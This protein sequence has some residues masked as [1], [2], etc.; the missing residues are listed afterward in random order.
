MLFKISKFALIAVL[1]VIAVVQ[2]ITYFLPD[3]V[4]R[5][6]ALDVALPENLSGWK[7]EVIPLAQTEELQNQTQEILRFDEVLSYRYTRGNDYITVYIAY[8]EPGKVPIRKVGV[9]TPDTCWVLNGWKREDRKYS[10]AKDVNGIAL[11]PCEYGLFSI[12]DHFE[13]VVFWHLVGG[14]VHSYE[15]HGLHDLF[16][17]IRD[18]FTKGLNQK[19]DQ[20]FI[21]ISSN[22]DLNE[23][24]Y[25]NGVQELIFAVGKLGAFAPEIDGNQSA[26]AATD[27]ISQ[28]TR[29]VSEVSVASR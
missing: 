28:T 25:D 19:A 21:R 8:W 15:Q 11:Q 4:T 16:S 14:K 5:T 7:G 17:P 18:L 2:V 22:R 23:L 10:Q 24:W 6:I 3:T 13:Y 1:V 27:S 9:H 20:Y 12:R 29:G 26:P